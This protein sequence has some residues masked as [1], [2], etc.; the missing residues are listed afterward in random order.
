M[1]PPPGVRGS[2]SQWND[3]RILSVLEKIRLQKE[4]TARL[5]QERIL[6]QQA[7]LQRFGMP[8]FSRSIEDLSGSMEG[9]IPEDYRLLPGDELEA[10]VTNLNGG[11]SMEAVVVDETGRASFTGLG[12]ISVEGLTRAQVESTVNSSLS[13]TRLRNMTARVRILQ[14]QK[15]RVFV[16]GEA[17]RPGGYL[18]NSGS[19]LLDALLRAG[20]PSETGSFRKITLQRN[21]RTI[22]T[23][24]LYPLLINGKLDSPR[25]L[26]GDRVFIPLAGD[27]ITVLGE[28]KRPAIYEL[29]GE[30]TLDQVI[31]LAG[32]AL[33][34]A[35]SPFV[36]IRRVT[37][38]QDR[39]VLDVPLKGSRVPV[40]GGDTV[41]VRT[42]LQDLTNGVYLEGAT[43][44]PGWYQLRPGM[45]IQDLLS[46]AEGLK[47]GAYGPHAEIFR[48]AAPEQP[49][50]MIGF[51]LDRALLGDPANNLTLARGDI[52]LIFSEDEAQF[53]Q[54]VR[55]QGQVQSPGEYPFHQSMRVRDLVLLAGGTSQEAAPMAEI[56]RSTPSGDV[57][58]IAFNV[59]RV[60]LSPQAADN[61]ELMSGDAVVIRPRLHARPFP[62]SVALVG[63]FVNPG[64]YFVNP[65][66][67]LRAVIQRAGG[68]TPAAYFPAAVLTRELPEIVSSDRQKVIRD[69]LDVIQ[70]VARQYAAA[71]AM[72]Q[73]DPRA[74]GRLDLT[75]ISDSGTSVDPRLLGA[76]LKTGR[77]PIELDQ[78]LVNG[79]GD[80]GVVDG[81]VLYVPLKPR[82]VSVVGAVSLPSG[83]I[84]RPGFSAFD[85]INRAGGFLHDAEEGEV[86]VMRANGELVRADRAGQIGP[87]DVVAVPNKAIVAKPDAFESFLQVLQAVVNGAV[88]FRVFN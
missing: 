80:P 47:E 9:I 20:G 10:T 45:R 7:T 12:P 42:V 58:I 84:W 59:E 49:L 28:V 75:S 11:S 54:R 13:R 34:E 26:M 41:L 14:A 44:R 4:E 76:I 48:R 57:Q 17:A 71:E 82:T 77:V 83:I 86:M 21:G 43:N 55:V 35:Y 78:I 38:N 39:I 64:V 27:Q 85:Y 3:L 8:F 60:M 16:L 18:M 52:V 40:R 1:G 36:Q 30:R 22:A 29:L 6:A 33:P 81:D 72:R 15:I 23:L 87:G 19:T 56:A 50:Q 24:D 25:L 74:A 31:R 88:L 65:G 68:L 79:N 66:E 37:G 51:S 32:G 62:A 67:D 5:Q 2:T 69:F 73:S 61:V 53:Q 63:E 46:Q 70:E